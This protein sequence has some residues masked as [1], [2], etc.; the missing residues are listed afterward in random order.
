MRKQR[1]TKLPTA[2]LSVK[3]RYVGYSGLVHSKHISKLSYGKSHN[4]A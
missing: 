4:L 1:D 2:P 3:A